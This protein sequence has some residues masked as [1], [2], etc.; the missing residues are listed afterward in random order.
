MTKKYLFRFWV[1]LLNFKID[2]SNQKQ[3]TLDE[4]VLIRLTTS[5]EDERLAELYKKYFLGSGYSKYLL[6]I[7]LGKEPPETEPGQFLDEAE[8]KI[9]KAI[10]IFRLFKKETIGYNLIVQPLSET[11]QYGYTARFQFYQKL[12]SS[13]KT[14]EI[15][16]LKESEIQPFKIFFN[17]FYKILFSRYDLAIEYFNKSYIEPYTPRDSF[18][19]LM[20]TLENLFLKN[21][22]QELSYKLSMR[23]AYILGKDK[24][25]RI[26]IYRF[27]KDAYN[28]RSKIV[29]GEKLDKLDNQRF[30]ELREL[31]RKSIIYFLENKDN[32]NGKKLDRLILEARES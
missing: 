25:D 1:S 23:M 29:H 22:S 12:W 7:I 17:N 20:I 6:E 27:I 19:D 4:D 13:E 15:Y 32:W 28:L 3:I 26:N 5:F 2:I 10:A 31:T 11:K 30:L 24:K 16:I 14:P 9:K 8:E 18:L 21:T